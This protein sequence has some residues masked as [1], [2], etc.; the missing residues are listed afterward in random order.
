MGKIVGAL[1]VVSGIVG[2]LAALTMWRGYV[3][4]VL[5]AWFVVSTFAVPALSIPAAIGLCLTVSMFKNRRKDNSMD[6]KEPWGQELATE[7]LIPLLALVLG[8]IVKL[9]M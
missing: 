8:W 3:L 1:S 9:W 2:V 7:A 4:T 5:W 6:E